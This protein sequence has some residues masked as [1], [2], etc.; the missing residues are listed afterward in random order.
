LPWSA[1]S[2]R[3]RTASRSPA[4][5]FVGVANG[6][7][8]GLLRDVVVR[9]VPTLLRPG[10]FVSLTLLFACGLFLVLTTRLAVNPTTAAW[11]TVG[12]YFVLR[13]IAVS[14]NWQTRPVLVESAPDSQDIRRD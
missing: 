3:R 8:G 1:C 9:D 14:F 11:I 7:T 6:V 12:T 10:Q 2:S 13:V 4:S 5:Y